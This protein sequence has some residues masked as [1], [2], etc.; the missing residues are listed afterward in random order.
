MLTNVFCDEAFYPREGF[1]FK[2]KSF[3]SFHFTHLFSTFWFLLFSSVLSLFISK[4]KIRKWEI[5][6]KI[7]VACGSNRDRESRWTFEEIK[8]NNNLRTIIFQLFKLQFVQPFDY[9]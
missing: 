4:R 6:R 1:E 7:W 3:I 5:R 8:S 2:E 9:L